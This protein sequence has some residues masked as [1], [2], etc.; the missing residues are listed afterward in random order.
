MRQATRL[1]GCARSHTEHFLFTDKRRLLP[2]DCRPLVLFAF[3]VDRRC[4]VAPLRFGKEHL[5]HR[6]PRGYIRMDDGWPLHPGRPQAPRAGKYWDVDLAGRHAAAEEDQADLSLRAPIRPAAPE[7]VSATQP[8]AHPTDLP[9]TPRPVERPAL[10]TAASTVEGAVLTL[11][12]YV[13]ACTRYQRDGG[14]ATPSPG[15]HVTYGTTSSLIS[16]CSAGAWTATV[17]EAGGSC[18][19]MWFHTQSLSA[20]GLIV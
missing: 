11:A 6:L 16:R 20:T 18:A 3:G 12:G 8:A 4:G 2:D 10:D 13:H 15:F 1:L 9:T 7:R 14:T 19:A 5:E 17:S